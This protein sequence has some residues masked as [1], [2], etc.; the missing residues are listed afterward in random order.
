[1]ISVV[2]ATF[3]GE[4]YVKRQLE[5]ILCQLDTDDEVIVSDDGSVDNTLSIITKLASV[6]PRIKVIN[7]PHK[8]YNKNFENAIK[9][10]KGEYIFI[11][12]QDDVWMPNKISII[13]NNFKLNPQV[14]CIRHDC[15]VVDDNDNVII[16]SYNAYRKSN[17]DYKSNIVKN[18]FTGCC[19]CVEAE[20]LKKLIPF[21]NE[22][23]Y[24][25]WIGILSC[26]YN[27]TMI[28]DNKLIKWC[29]HEGTVT[30][31]KK[32]NSLI[33]ILKNR[34]DLYRNIRKKCKELL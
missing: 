27:K 23:F 20:W 1:M 24:D 15:I 31:A 12:D 5:S 4:K 3:N 14:K 28:I 22:I 6:D 34:C 8:G 26:K 18:T 25:A 9:Y 11:S 17:T 33:H 7:G 2:M 30:N 32:R 16:D 29:R 10:A 21:P 19:M 13:L